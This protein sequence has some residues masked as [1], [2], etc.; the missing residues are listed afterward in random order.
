[1][2]AAGAA[3]VAAAGAGAVGDSVK[4]GGPSPR[5]LDLTVS[6]VYDDGGDREGIVV[7]IEDVTDL[8]RV[9]REKREGIKLFSY[10]LC[11]I[12]LFLF[13]WQILG[14]FMEVPNWLMARVMELLT[15]SLAVFALTQTSMTLKDIGLIAPPRQ[16]RVTLI[17]G[18]TIGATIIVLFAVIRLILNQSMPAITASVPFFDWH[19]DEAA[20]QTYFFVAPFQELLAKGIVLTGLLR[21]FY[22][23]KNMLPIVFGSSMLFAAMHVN[24]GISMMMVAFALC[25]ATGWLYLKDRNIWGCAIVH[26]CLGF[27]VTCF[28]FERMFL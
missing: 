2:A 27:F 10:G 8:V 9:E 18:A 16:I 13:I 22:D 6:F 20:Q 14:A 5:S 25:F 4:K 7:L 19:L 15:L 3:G 24:Y 1:V 23:A 11:V 21:I 28:G 26:F 17:R 12:V